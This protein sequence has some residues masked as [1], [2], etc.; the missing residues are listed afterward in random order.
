MSKI[1]PTRG[2]LPPSNSKNDDF[3][4]DSLSQTT[5][6]KSEISILR[7]Q[8]RS[9][10]EQARI[11]RQTSAAELDELRNRVQ[12]LEAAQHDTRKSLRS[13]QVS[14]RSIPLPIEETDACDNTL[15]ILATKDFCP[16]RKQED[17]RK[18][19]STILAYQPNSRLATKD[20]SPARKQEDI[21]TYRSITLA[22]QPNSRF[23]CLLNIL[24]FVQSTI[25]SL[26]YNLS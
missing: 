15:G 19:R 6:A 2:D 18:Y 25:D 16:A 10:Q 7:A 22:Y 8:L 5:D 3:T 20:F 1:Y 13:T 23:L 21:R 12:A 11:F 24:K 4:N 14:L 17:L 9:F 26:C